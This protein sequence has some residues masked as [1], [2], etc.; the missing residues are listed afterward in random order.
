VPFAEIDGDSVVIHNF[1]N[2]D[3]RSETDY[4]QRW[5]TKTLHLSNLR[6]ID[7]FLD[8]WRSPRI[9]HTFLSFD[10]GAER[11]GCASIETRK[12]MGQTY[13]AL[14]GFY[15]QYTLCYVIGDERDIVRLRTNYRREDLYLYRMVNASPEKSRKLFLDYIR[16]ANRFS[17]HPQWYN[18]PNSNFTRKNLLPL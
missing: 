2:F 16:T 10:F 3:Y 13:S 14:R 11:H 8:Y 6:G 15:R 4:D 5:E 18:T 9:C 1:R 12:T 7:F 17:Q